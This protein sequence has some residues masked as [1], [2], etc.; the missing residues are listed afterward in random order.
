MN[1]KH[2][3]DVPLILSRIILPVLLFLSF[4][5]QAKPQA[6]VIFIHS[7][8]SDATAWGDYDTVLVE[9]NGWLFGGCPRVFPSGVINICQNSQ[10]LSRGDFY[11]LEFSDPQNLDFGQQGLELRKIIDAVLAVNPGKSQVILVGH[12]MGGLASRYYLQF[13]Y[14]NNNGDCSGGRGVSLLPGDVWLMR[15]EVEGRCPGKSG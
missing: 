11:R 4:A 2:R 3:F 10:S 5:V 12:S 6:P 9:Q 1:T 13:A 8:G 15:S 14:K 7:L